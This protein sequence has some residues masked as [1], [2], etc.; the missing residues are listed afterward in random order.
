MVKWITF[1]LAQM[2]QKIMRHVSDSKKTV[3]FGAPCT[4]D[5]CR[6]VSV[7]YTNSDSVYI[8][9]YFILYMM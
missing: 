1:L 2:L 9:F 3:I 7:D 5:T 6:P 4:I 8:N